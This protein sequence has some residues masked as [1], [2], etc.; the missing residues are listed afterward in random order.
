MD[1]H[2]VARKVGLDLSALPAGLY[3]Q[4]TNALAE[5]HTEGYTKGW[6]AAHN[7]GRTTGHGPL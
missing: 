1:M 3:T 7:S 2:A 4:V 6:W 5:A